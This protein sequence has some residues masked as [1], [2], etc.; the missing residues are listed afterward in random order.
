MKPYE[1]GV[2]DDIDLSDDASSESSDFTEFE[3]G[4][5]KDKKFTRQHKI[6]DLD[7]GNYFFH[8]LIL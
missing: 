3:P 7:S 6:D 4:T 2:L 8:S 5:A 1:N